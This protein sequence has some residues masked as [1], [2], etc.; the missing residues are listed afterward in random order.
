[1]TCRTGPSIIGSSNRSSRPVLITPTYVAGELKSRDRT[2]YFHAVQC[3]AGLFLENGEPI[4]E[5]YFDPE[6][7]PSFVQHRLRKLNRVKP[8]SL[9]RVATSREIP[10][11]GLDDA[12]IKIDD[13][14]SR[15]STTDG[16]P[17]GQS[18]SDAVR[19]STVRPQPSPDSTRSPT[20]LLILDYVEADAPTWQLVQASRRGVTQAAGPVCEPTGL[21]PC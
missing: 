18:I 19:A 10:L 13:V 20:Q 21:M 9:R 11:D 14:S 5:I 1:M 12:A 3:P 7:K 15:S 16:P 8:P 2:V 6:D 17:T 4:R